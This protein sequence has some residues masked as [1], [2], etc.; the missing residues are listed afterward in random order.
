MARRDSALALTWLA[1]ALAALACAR[2]DV[3][4][5]PPPS[6]TP[7][8]PSP[9][10]LAS[11]SMLFAPTPTATPFAPRST[12]L[13]P[14]L[15]S[16]P[17]AS[18]ATPPLT[19][20]AYPHLSGV[21]AHAREI[22][23][24][25]QSLGNRPNVF[26]KV[27][28]SIT[29]SAV[30][31]FPIGNREYFLYDDYAYLE[32]VIHYF[33]TEA[34]RDQANSFNN[35]P[36]A[37]KTNWRAA[38]MFSPASANAEVCNA[39]EAPLPCEYRLVRPSIALIMLGTNDAPLTPPDTYE[40]DLRRV[41]EYSIDHG[42]IPVLSTLPHLARKG[43]EGNDAPLSV[44]IIRLAQEYDIPLWD[45]AAA[46][47]A[48]PNRGLYKDGIH[49]SWAPTGHAADFSPEYLQYGMTVRN[50]MALQMLDMLWREV[51]EKQ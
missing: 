19:P 38:A 10:P 49:P 20:L 44:I 33:S 36:L 39:G 51:I 7:L 41:I 48:L 21:T 11:R 28:D 2:S 31:L 42:V 13:A 16:T 47:E 50:L 12:L 45:F 5:A 26:S 27:G 3:L 43:Y 14:T 30:F 32:P 22:F 24:R 17:L 40:Q 9:S 15:T 18:T 35:I 34:A 29:A 23:V 1:L 4:A 37:A 6:A 25:G 46:L 8:A